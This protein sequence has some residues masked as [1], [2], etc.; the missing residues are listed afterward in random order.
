MAQMTYY[1]LTQAAPTDYFSTRSCYFRS[2]DVEHKHWRRLLWSVPDEMLFLLAKG[3][4]VRI[5][6]KSTRNKGKIE[7]VFCPVLQVLVNYLW[8]QVP[9]PDKL[10]SFEPHSQLA[11][12]ALTTDTQLYDRFLFWKPFAKKKVEVYGFTEKI[13]KELSKEVLSRGS[14][15]DWYFV[16]KAGNNQVIAQS[17]GYT[18]K[19]NALKGIAS[20]KKNAAKARIEIKEEDE[21]EE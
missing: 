2:S 10:Y 20:V 5:Y 12:S 18:R 17:E 21:D 8:F 4:T 16:L 1:N 15:G 14:D 13:K 3:V 9:L 19:R 7:M 6:D 11:L